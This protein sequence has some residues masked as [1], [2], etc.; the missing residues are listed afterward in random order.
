M[1]WQRVGHDWV[2]ELN[3]KVKVKVSQQS[4]LTLYDPRH[5]SPLG[6]SVH[7]ILQARVLVWVAISFSRGSSQPRHQTQVSYIVGRH[8]TLWATREVSWI[9]ELDQKESWVPKNWC[10]WTVVLGEDFW[11]SL[12]LQGDPTS[13]SEGDQP[14]DFFGR[15][16]AKAETLVLVPLIFFL[17]ISYL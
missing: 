4:C 9:W 16:D 5:Y 12:G 1:A 15:N 3:R 7:G 13:H 8:L 10:F 17:L 6:S 14:W 11:E 2:T